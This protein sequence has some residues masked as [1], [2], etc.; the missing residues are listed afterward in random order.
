MLLQGTGGVSLFALQIAT[1]LGAR[2]IV[3]CSDDTKMAKAKA[4]GAHVC[5]DRRIEPQWGRCVRDDTT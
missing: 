3:V 2:C 5:I 1:A 4:L